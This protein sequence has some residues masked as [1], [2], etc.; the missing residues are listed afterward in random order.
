MPSSVEIAALAR[1]H[2][3]ALRAR[4]DTEPN[5]QVG[6]V[7]IKDDVV[8]GEGYHAEYGGPHA[9]IAALRAAGVEAQGSTAIVTLEP[10]STT[11]KTG[12][13]YK[14]LLAAG[15]V[16]VVV[17]AIDPNPAHA[18][19]GLTLLRGSG[20]E[21]EIV[22]D[23]GCQ[24]LIDRF[25]RTLVSKRP[26][27]FAKW[28]MS[29]D[30]AIAGQ[31]GETARLSGDEARTRVHRWRRALD[32][33]VVGVQTIVADDP[34]LTAR[35]ES[36]PLR[37]LHRI[38][39]DPSLRTPVFA[40]VVTTAVETPTWIATTDKADQARADELEQHGVRILRAPSGERW[41]HDVL[42]MLRLGALQRVMVEGG[43]RTLAAFLDARIVDQ[44]AVL[45]SKKVLGAGALPAV[46]GRVLPGDDPEALAL[47]L[48]LEEVRTERLGDDLLLRG[49]RGAL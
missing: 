34:E 10:C 33:I 42:A 24:V 29:R 28:A 25:A 19:R 16:R 22:D 32:G 44:V 9:E 30:G 48:D 3:L 11:G 8:V 2:A 41:L 40:R 47:A 14:A 12:P 38:V 26:H 27:V 35:G 37:P 20:V 21:L 15:V 18:G 49:Q 7:L 39:L 6:C 43:A 5:P 46:A 13:C 23:P 4:G 36:S 17:G 45:M 1:A 31:G